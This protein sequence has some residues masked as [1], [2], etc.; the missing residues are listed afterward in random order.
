MTRQQGQRD[1][2]DRVRNEQ[3]AAPSRRRILQV[4]A[5]LAAGALAATALERDD[6]AAAGPV[7]AQSNDANVAAVHGYNST[8]GTG[9]WGRTIQGIG[10]WGIAEQNAGDGV[11]GYAADTGRAFS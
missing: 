2:I 9:V 1:V 5:A 6:A 7:V 8:S 10:V 4:G 3:E 11:V